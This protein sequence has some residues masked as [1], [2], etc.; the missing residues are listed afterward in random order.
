MAKMPVSI[1]VNGQRYEREV[2][3]RLLLS[4]FIRHEIG[5]TGTH[6]GCENGACGVCAVLINGKTGLSCLAFAVQCDG[7]EIETIESLGTPSDL[8]PIQE[9][10]WENHGLQCGFCTPAMV[11]T[12]HELLSRNASPS[13]AEIIEAIGGNLCR[14]TGYQTIVDSIEQAAEQMRAGKEEAA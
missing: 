8:H 7:D 6:V 1:T 13:R 5:L 9:A 10:F 3:P 2:D 4:D 12:A 14:C 11:L